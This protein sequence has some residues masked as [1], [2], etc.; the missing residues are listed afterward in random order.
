MGDTNTESVKKKRKRSKKSKSS[1]DI[2]TN[3]TE[4]VDETAVKT[5]EEDTTD[6]SSSAKDVFVLDRSRKSLVPLSLLRNTAR[7]THKHQL[8]LRQTTRRPHFIT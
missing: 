8:S 3:N 2:A 6:N 1:S 4:G 5:S 7:I